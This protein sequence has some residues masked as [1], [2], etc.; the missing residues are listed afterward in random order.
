MACSAGALLMRANAKSSRSFILPTMFD[1][2]LEWT[3]VVLSPSSAPPL[4]LFLTAS[5]PLVQIY[6]SPQPS[7]SIK[8]KDGAHNI[9]YEITEHSL[10]DAEVSWEIIKKK[11]GWCHYS[12]GSI[13]RRLVLHLCR[14]CWFSSLPRG[15]PS[16]P[17]VFI[18]QQRQ[19]L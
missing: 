11:Q 13:P 12:P 6:F 7:A 16:C 4:S 10:C 3:V 9:R 19:T 8:I 18:P 17:P 15:S 14:F 1:L 5:A 2:Q